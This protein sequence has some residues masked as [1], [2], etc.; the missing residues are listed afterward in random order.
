[1]HIGRDSLK[2]RHNPALTLECHR[3]F[4]S[5]SLYN[6]NYNELYLL[7]DVNTSLIDETMHRNVKSFSHHLHIF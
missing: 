6:N 7:R 1:M 4:A 5:L 3:L 2:D